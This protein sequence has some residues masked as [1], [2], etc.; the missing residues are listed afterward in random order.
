MVRD[1]F[2]L[3][4]ELTFVLLMYEFKVQDPS[5]LMPSH[6]ITFFLTVPTLHLSVLCPFISTDTRAL[7]R[8][9]QRGRTNTI[10]SDV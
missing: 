6:P 3:Y 2:T 5:C 7:V 9:L 10:Y 8:V 1:C 4:I